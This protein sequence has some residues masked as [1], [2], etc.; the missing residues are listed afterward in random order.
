MNSKVHTG[1][2]VL[3]DKKNV[4]VGEGRFLV[5]NLATDFSGTYDATGGVEA[6]VVRRTP[7]TRVDIE[8]GKVPKDS[9]LAKAKFELQRR[10]DSRVAEVGEAAKRARRGKK[11]LISNDDY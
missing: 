5:A 6:V 11:K 4:V 1:L 9:S 10:V 2:L 8:V 3:K 7:G